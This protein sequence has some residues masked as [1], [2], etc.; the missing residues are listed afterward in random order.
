[1][2]ALSGGCGEPR[3]GDESSGSA[4]FEDGRL[5]VYVVN[6]PL[7]YFA[8]RIGGD[9]VDVAFPAPPGEDPAYWSPDMQAVSA[10]QGADLILLNGADYAK[11]VGRVT[12]PA[13]KLVNTSTAFADTYLPVEGSVTHSHGPE[14]EHA[15]GEI[16]FTTWLD[17]TLAVEQARAIQLAFERRMPEGAASFRDGFASLERDLLDLD[18]S[19]AELTA[20][21]GLPLVASHPVYQYLARRYDLDLESVHF[22]PGADPGDRGW[23]DLRQLLVEHPAKWMVWEGEPLPPVADRLS[24]LGVTS[25]VFDPC[26]NAPASG[27]YLSVMRENASSL[28]DVFGNE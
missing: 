8:E 23:Y 15:H 16:A 1:M 20:G 9:L 24:E 7:Q 13:S 22:E 4:S 11:W 6:Y 19:F 14:G 12:L 5:T 18:A 17:P 25:V 27:D 10:Y 26:A 3:Q 21:S 28:A 2:T